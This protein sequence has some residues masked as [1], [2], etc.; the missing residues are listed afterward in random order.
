MLIQTAQT[1]TY[2]ADITD[3]TSDGILVT[4]VNWALAVL[5]VI[6]AGLGGKFAFDAWSEGKG[7]AAVFKELRTIGLST[8][9]VEAFYALIFTVANYGSNIASLIPGLGG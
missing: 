3:P 1:I 8:L 2:L 7:K 9:A 5:A 4:L 6:T